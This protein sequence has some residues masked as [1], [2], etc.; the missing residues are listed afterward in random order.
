MI[1]EGL[2]SEQQGDRARIAA[3]VRW[4]DSD[5]PTQDIYFETQLEF[6][7]DLTCNPH[8]FLV[9]CVM[10]AFHH[11]E[12]RIL[13]DEEICPELRDGLTTVM[14]WIRHWQYEPDTELVQIEAKARTKVLTADK[15]QRAA[16]FIS[17]GVDGFAALRSNRLQYPLE[18]PGLFKDGIVVYGLHPEE[19]DYF[20]Q[21]LSSLSEITHEQG[22]TLIP[23]RTNI[24]SLG[25][26]WEFWANEFFAAAFA[27]VAHAFTK[28]FSVVSLASAGWGIP[29]I[30]PH[31]SHPLIDPN[32]SSSDLRVRHEG[33]RLSRLDKVRLLVG[34][35]LALEHLRVCNTTRDVRPDRLNCGKCEKCVR[36]ML[37]FLVLGALD[38]NPAFEASDVSPK[39]V[40]SSVYIDP[41]D[42]PFY[43]ELLEPL[44]ELGRDDLVAAIKSKLSQY[45]RVE[46]L[47]R[48]RKYIKRLDRQYNNNRLVKLKRIVMGHR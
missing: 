15:A 41:I 22:I 5:R 25:N 3:T 18:H 31:G 23:I 45:Q 16:V 29:H 38:K 40:R 13:I 39:L 7:K 9:G 8:A 11:G 43:E 46:K 2:R 26:G 6:V 20:R 14:S 1:I 36:T 28:R 37:E 44:N 17:G 30:F 10:P 21:T 48:F 19:P 33:A 4:E 34:W 32:Y 47:T 27:S 12:K 24:V 35:D 42:A